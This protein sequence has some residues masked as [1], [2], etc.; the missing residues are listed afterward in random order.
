MNTDS[1]STS[2]L[3]DSNAVCPLDRRQPVGDDHDGRALFRLHQDLLD[4]R[5][6]LPV[7][8]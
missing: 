7:D 3:Q 4:L 5:F 1:L 6:R 8:R 2:I